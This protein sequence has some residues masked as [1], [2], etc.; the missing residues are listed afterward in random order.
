MEF[1]VMSVRGQ[2]TAGSNIVKDVN[3][4]HMLDKTNEIQ[5]DTLFDYSKK[6]NKKNYVTPNLI[7]K[8]KH[9]TLPVATAELYVL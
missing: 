8:W 3:W 2:G 5:S 7:P 1:G 6:T 4:G 9:L